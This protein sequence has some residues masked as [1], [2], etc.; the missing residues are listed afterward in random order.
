MFK[1]I[2]V[3]STFTLFIMVLI[4][5]A[6]G[7]LPSAEEPARKA[8]ELINRRLP[9]TFEC[10]FCHNPG[11]ATNEKIPHST[12][13][14]YHDKLVLEDQVGCFICHDFD[15]R[16]KLRLLSG[17]MISFEESPRLC[18][19]CHQKRYDTWLYGDHGKSKPELDLT[20]DASHNN[21]TIEELESRRYRC[22]DFRCHNPHN[23]KLYKVGLGIGYPLPPPLDP[24]EVV[25]FM[26]PG[27]DEPYTKAVIFSGQIFVAIL[28]LTLMMFVILMIGKDKWRPD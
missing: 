14:E 19:Q 6:Y 4:G 15:Q 22:S 3:L 25:N 7:D 18:Y 24:P 5:P 1:K 16:S 12:S 9:F 28:V 23:P 17:E 26:N 2:I 27:N 13:L 10:D 8:D 21:T 20:T 11:T